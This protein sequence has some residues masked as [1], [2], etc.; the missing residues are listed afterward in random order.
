[1]IKMRKKAH[2]APGQ[3]QLLSRYLDA[4]RSGRLLSKTNA[5]A[6]ELTSSDTSEIVG[7]VDLAQR[8]R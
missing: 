4:Y 5:V 7:S 6:G 3:D 1:M 2:L 8:T